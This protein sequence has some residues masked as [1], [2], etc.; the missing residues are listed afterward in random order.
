MTKTTVT[1]SDR[2]VTAE[3]TE[4]LVQEAA[5]QAFASFARCPQSPLFFQRKKQN[6]QTKEEEEEEKERKRDFLYLSVSGLQLF[7]LTALRRTHLYLSVQPRRRPAMVND[8]R[9]V[10]DLVV[11][12]QGGHCDH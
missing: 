7:S 2:Q 4:G 6:K 1:G 3:S 5:A 12:V 9:H 10:R 11:T 8:Q